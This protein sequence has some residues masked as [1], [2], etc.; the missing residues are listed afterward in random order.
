MFGPILNGA[1][2][3]A[4][5]NHGIDYRNYQCD[6]R[7]AAFDVFKGGT[8]SALLVLPTGTGKTVLAGMCCE[9]ALFNHGRRTLFVAHREV[10]INQAYKT[11]SRFGF[12]VSVEMG[13]RDALKLEATLGKSQIVVGSIQTLQD[14]RLLRWNPNSF[15]QIIVDECHWAL[16]DMYTK[17]LNHF[18][19]Y[20]LLGITATPRRGDK[21]NL[22]S[23]FQ[24]KA[25]EYS[26]RRAIQEQWLVPI[27]TRV[28]PAK[29]DLRGIKLHGGDFSIG[30]L[31]ERIG[32]MMEPLA[33][34]FL[35]EVGRR[36]SVAFLPDVGSAMAFAQL[37]TDLGVTSRYVAGTGGTFGMSKAERY[38]NL[39]AFNAGEYQVIT[40]N[41][42][43]VE[44]WDCPRVEA[45]GIVRATLQQH[46]YTQMVGRGTRPSPDTGKRDCLVIDFDWETDPEVKDLCSSIEL[47]DD[48]S[49]DEDVFAV[50]RT[51]AK[52]RAVDIDPLEVIE[53]AERIVRTRQRFMIKLTGKEAAYASYEFDPVGVAKIL[54]IPLK[55]KYDLDKKGVNP[56]T[57]KQ[58]GML[59]SLGITAPEGLSKWG[60]SKMIGKIMK[61]QEQG[62]ATTGQVRDL[63]AAGVNADYARVMSGVEAAAALREIG[64]ASRY[65]QGSLFE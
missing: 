44:G 9:E 24:V 49:L 20:W 45:V 59:K 21:R 28:C 57:D 58:L 33:R 10:L 40:C 3:K 34:G 36:P 4:M 23:R 55:R 39:E 8:E 62:Y 12:D 7:D 38:A 41:E 63:L 50:A 31:E 11:L 30:D 32:P 51:I 27:K 15:G 19:D 60:A 2:S 56:A 48:G 13:S 14:D 64:E 42:L 18:E 29:V 22:G 5:L 16:T 26:L 65:V 47:F 54:D 17:A 53:E 35:K 52:E 46:R 61:R 25:Y 43:L 1:M 37:C 6:A